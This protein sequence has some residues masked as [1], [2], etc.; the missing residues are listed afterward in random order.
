MKIDK[1]YLITNGCS[2]TE[3][4]NIQ[5]IS[6]AHYLSKELD[7]EL[8]NLGKGGTG[9]QIIV[10]NTINYATIEKDKADNAF[11]VIQ[12]SECLR[13]LINCDIWD[14]NQENSFY[15]H[16]TPGQFIND[17]GFHGWDLTFKLNKHIYDNRYGLA[18]FYSN[19]TFSLIQTFWAIIN[20]VNFCERNNY[21][22][23]IFDGLNNH[24]PYEKNG[25]W[26]L[27]FTDPDNKG[28]APYE[29]KV[30]NES[31]LKTFI[32]D[33]QSAILH[34]TLIDYIS[35]LNFYYTD[36]TLWKFVHKRE[37]DDYIKGNGG[38][39]NELGSKMWAKYLVEIIE[40]KYGDDGDK[41]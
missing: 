10:Q 16:I 11:F 5:P 3:G 15:W 17:N 28:E 38:H 26:F 6:W 19:I 25:K 8:I 24:V 41:K 35:D 34:K 27:P 33:R 36:N 20:F 31:D 14:N 7:L 9:N 12:L 37:T 21:P 13:Y 1:K 2:F 32:K 30:S 22:Y 39:P 18:P 40:E 4:H 23:L 29:L